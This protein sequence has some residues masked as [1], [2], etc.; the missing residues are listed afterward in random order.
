[1][2]SDKPAARF[3]C[4]MDLKSPARRA[5]RS[6]PATGYGRADKNEDAKM[7]QAVVDLASRNG[8]R[9]IT[10]NRKP[11]SLVQQARFDEELAAITDVDASVASLVSIHASS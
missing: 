9:A 8:V 4:V 6:L 5:I 7:T 11:H 1:M 3:G 2:T 10:V